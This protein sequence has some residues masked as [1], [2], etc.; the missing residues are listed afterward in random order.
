MRRTA[1][2]LAYVAVFWVALPIGLWWI[3]RAVDANLGLSTRPDAWGTVP[4]V[5]GLVLMASSFATLWRS[6]GGLPVS[7]L[8][9]PR[10]TRRGPYGHVRHPIYLGFNLAVLGVGL[11]AGSAGLA[12]VVAPAFAPIWIGYASLEE[13]GLRRR[14]GR[15]YRRYASRVGLLPQVRLYRATRAM[16]RV[17]LPVEATR[18]EHVPSEGPAVL[19]ANHAC[20][21][22]P[23]YIG[24]LTPRTIHFLA[25]AEAYRSP[26]LGDF[27]RRVHGIP[28]RRYRAD[29]IACRE[30]LRLLDEGEVVGLF[31]EGERSV[32]GNYLGARRD[33]ARIVARLGVPVI[34][35]GLSGSYDCGPRWASVLRRRP[36]RVRAG[37]ALAWEGRAPAE[38]LDAA[39]RGLL[40]SDP[41]PV[42]LAGLPR[43]HLERILWRCPRCA[44]EA[45]WQAA[46]LRCD[47]CGA[48]Y[49]PTPEGSLV[50]EDGV[51]TM[52]STLGKAVRD[53]PEHDRL[54][55]P[56]F[57]FREKSLFGAPRPLLSLGAGRLD[58][59]EERLRF[60]PLSLTLAEI[61]T[62]SIERADTLQIATAG[63]MW[64]FRME[65]GS[66]FRLEAALE[67]WRAA[68]RAVGPAAEALCLS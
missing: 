61:R 58:I 66:A 26:L 54:S 39:I 36:V 9:P 34:P 62:V 14:F 18:A 3:A 52:L 20:Y 27:L 23:W 49:E 5:A 68:V 59:D 40:E 33:V 2:V 7:A 57:G 63:G 15:A 43:R 37:P 53:A 48:R 6:A 41:Q 55:T 64:Q 47:S 50:G 21:L 35:V 67:R 24:R 12:W 1:I 17:L 10:L 30:V 4:L 25:T 45:G 38:L 56:A 8:P 13:R 22:D 44:A 46:A 60:G 11:V 28:V 32:L 65:S 31:P 29:P 19:V 16:A 51:T 42:R